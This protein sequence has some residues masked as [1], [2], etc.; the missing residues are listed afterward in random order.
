MLKQQ[1]FGTIRM[2]AKKR[3]VDAIRIQCRTKWVA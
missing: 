1:Q 2:A 3:E